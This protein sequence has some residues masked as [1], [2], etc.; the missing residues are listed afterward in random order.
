MLQYCDMTPESR[1]SLFLGNGSVNIFALK[2]TRATIA[3]AFSVIRT[4]LV[5]T[6]GYSKHIFAVVK[7]TTVQVTTLPL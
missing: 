7:L 1:N 3:A 4:A 5:A 6:Q 2:R